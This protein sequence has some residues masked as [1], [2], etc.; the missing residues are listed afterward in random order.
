LSGVAI[1]LQVVNDLTRRQFLGGLI[2]L[3]VLGGCARDTGSPSATTTDVRLAHDGGEVTLPRVPSRIVTLGEEVTEFAAVLGIQPVGVGSA[4]VNSALGDQ[5]FDGYYLTPAQIGSPRYVGPGPFNLE[6]I[7]A[8]RPDLIV[9]SYQ[10]DQIT[11]LNEIAPTVLYEFYGTKGSW[12]E[13]LSRLGAALG[14]EPQAAAAIAAYEGAV[15]SGRSRLSDLISRAGRVSIVYPNYQG[16]GS[17][18]VYAAEHSVSRPVADL[19]FKVTGIEKITKVEL[20]GYAEISTELLSDLDTDTILT[21]GPVN[22]KQTSSAVVLQGVDMPVVWV[23]SPSTQ[24]TT[25]PITALDRLNG[26]VTALLTGR[27]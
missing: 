5:V 27:G 18:Y 16:R 22:W 23:P 8:V 14:R 3:G 6:A 10:D 25:G 1:E 20:D 26:Y 19:G 17:D 4:R 24:P 12:Q 11:Q 13:S 15:A 21:L 7:A 9:H 2:A